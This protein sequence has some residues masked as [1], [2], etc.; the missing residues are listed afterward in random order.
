VEA[1]AGPASLTI[2]EPW[3]TKPLEFDSVHA[4]MTR[5]DVQILSAPGRLGK[6][7]FDGTARV[8]RGQLTS[9]LEA[10]GDLEELKIACQPVFE[11]LYIDGYATATATFAIAPQVEYPGDAI[12]SMQRII[13]AARQDRIDFQAEGEFSNAAFNHLSMPLLARDLTGLLRCDNRT[14]YLRDVNGN[15]GASRNFR[16]AARIDFPKEDLPLVALSIHTP[17][18]SI[19][20]WVDS[21]YQIDAMLPKNNEG[22]LVNL[23]TLSE[24]SDNVF[25]MGVDLKADRWEGY[26]LRGTD[27]R[28]RLDLRIPDGRDGILDIPYVKA[29]A[30]NGDA[31]AAY[32]MTLPA[33]PMD[34][35]TFRLLIDGEDLRLN[36]MVRDVSNNPSTLS[37]LLN[38]NLDLQGKAGDIQTLAGLAEVSVSDSNILQIPIFDPVLSRI[39]LDPARLIESGSVQGDI[40]FDGGDYIFNDFLIRH[41]LVNIVL[42]GEL[43]YELMLNMEIIAQFTSRWVGG[44]PI[45]KHLGYAID[46]LSNQFLSLKATG[47]LA[48]PRIS[49]GPVSFLNDTFRRLFLGSEPEATRSFQSRATQGEIT[50]LTIRIDA[51]N[52]EHPLELDPQRLEHRP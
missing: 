46:D 39:G 17:R 31:V 51:M 7:N 4:R 38:G 37:G 32:L 8:Y 6:L 49:A 12:N 18:F 29:K 10:H 30:Y 35:P 47:R 44:L 19:D 15:L 1:K 26:N 11:T 2:P 24:P 9:T 14:L 20:D 28:G 43:S 41:P 16:A 22:D 13:D 48:S 40:Q 52:L 34:L 23:P 21:W 3:I 50:D 33:D 42:N 27:L 36:P 45:L 5:Q 25:R